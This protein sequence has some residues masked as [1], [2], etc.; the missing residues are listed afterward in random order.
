MRS[1]FETLN[2]SPQPLENQALETLDQARQR[3]CDQ[4]ELGRLLLDFADEKLIGEVR[5]AFELH[6]ESCESCRL[7]LEIFGVAVD[8]M[9]KTAAEKLK[10]TGE[11]N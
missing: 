9:K 7:G 6:L 5:E 8:E 2:E 10:K 4:P 11:L 1:Q 3:G